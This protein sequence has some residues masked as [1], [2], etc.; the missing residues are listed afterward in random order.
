MSLPA[1]MRFVDLPRFGAP[2]VMTIA[3]GPLPVAGEGQI[4]V[5]TEAIGVNRPDVAQRQGTYPPPRD[6]SPILGLELA[7]EVVAIG[8]A[9][10]AMPSATR[11]AALPMAAPMP[12]IACC[13]PA[14]L[15]LS[16]R[17]TMRSRRRR[18]RKT[19]SPSGPTCSRWPA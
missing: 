6:A 9:S 3:T 11:S 13:R 16:P 18:F 17:V 5:R 8:P 10:A 19:I 15:C 4:L 1:L 2:E 7:G 12:N 14:R